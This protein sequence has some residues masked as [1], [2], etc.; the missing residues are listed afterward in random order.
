MKIAPED[1][2]VA[3]FIDLARS[4]HIYF[5]LINN[6]VTVRAVN[7]DWKMWAP[8]RHCLDELGQARIEA[9]V[10]SKEHDVARLQ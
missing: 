5:D 9:Y 4:A 8:I 3:E 7:P 2:A 1:A 6:R 10:R